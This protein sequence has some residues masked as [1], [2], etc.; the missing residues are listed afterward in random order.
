MAKYRF[1]LLNPNGTVVEG[2]LLDCAD[3]LAALSNARRFCAA[4]NVDIWQAGRHVAT[5][6]MGN[7]P[8]D[9]HDRVSL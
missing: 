1:F 7:A 5:V 8:L 2:D 3:D 9:I 4:N 6:K